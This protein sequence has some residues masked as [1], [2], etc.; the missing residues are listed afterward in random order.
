MQAQNPLT[1]TLTG[2]GVDRGGGRATHLFSPISFRSLTAKNRVMVAPMCQYSATDGVANAWHV[3]H[4]SSRAVGGPGIVCIE[5]THVTAEGRITPYCLGLWNDTQRDAL[6]PVVAGIEAQGA[7]PAIQLAHAGR[8]ASTSQPWTGSQPVAPEDG[9]WQPI[10]ASPIAMNP[11]GLVPREMTKDDIAQVVAD[12]VASAKLALEAGFKIVEIHGAHG[13]L[14][15]S[16]LS[17][18]ANQRTD[19]YGGS[20]ANR[21]R[22]LV[23]VTAAVQEVWPDDLPVF[24]RL[25]CSDWVEGGLTIADTVEVSKTLKAMGV[26]LI[27]CSSGGVDADQHIPLSPGYQVPFARQIRAEAD[28]PTG[29][30]VLIT[31]PEHSESI[32]ADGSADLIILARAL[33]ADPMWPMRAA[34]VLKADVSWPLQYERAASAF[35]PA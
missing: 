24:V 17:P 12:F 13:Y 6:K 31:S 10:G 25:S 33:L 11:G 26:D 16:F 2:P 21:A 34:K 18:R 4:I 19:E 23:E 20:L 7:I 15:H 9:G 14:L 32:L 35:Y 28:I 30:V 1:T 29:A 22:A 8:K 5:A 3:Q 27:D